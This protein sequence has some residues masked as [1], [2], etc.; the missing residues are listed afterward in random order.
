MHY[1]GNSLT[2]IRL[3]RNITISNNTAG[4]RAR[5]DE[6]RTSEGVFEFHTSHLTSPQATG[7]VWGPQVKITGTSMHW[8]SVSLSVLQPSFSHDHGVALE[9]LHSGYLAKAVHPE[10]PWSFTNAQASRFQFYW[11]GRAWA[12]PT[13]RSMSKC[14]VYDYLGTSVIQ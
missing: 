14:D 8:L 4:N 2:K 1:F 3:V 10:F 13:S 9:L 7:A 6:G 12:P 5:T 11:C